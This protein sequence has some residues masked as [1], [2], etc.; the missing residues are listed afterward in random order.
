M[1]INFREEHDVGGDDGSCGSCCKNGVLT[2]IE[3]IKSGSN[4]INGFGALFFWN[5]RRGKGHIGYEPNYS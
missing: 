3:D 4:K 1:R 2:S 5:V